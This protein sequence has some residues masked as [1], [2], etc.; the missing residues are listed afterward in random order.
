MLL[1]RESD[2]FHLCVGHLPSKN[3]YLFAVGDDESGY[4]KLLVASKLT[5][6]LSVSLG[7]YSVSSACGSHPS[8]CRKLSME[9]IETGS[10][11]SRHIVLVPLENG[12]QILE[13]IY[14]GTSNNQLSLVTHH[15]LLFSGVNGNHSCGPSLGVHKIGSDYFIPCIGTDN[16]YYVCELMLNLTTIAQSV[17]QPCR[18][19]DISNFASGVNLSSISNIAVINES[20]VFLIENVLYELYPRTSSNRPFTHIFPTYCSS[21]SQLLISPQDENKLLIYHRNHNIITY[22]HNHHQ[23]TRIEE[24]SN[25]PYPCSPTAEYIVHLSQNQL[26]F[27]YKLNN[28]SDTVSRIFESP[29]SSINFHSGACFESRGNHLFVYIDTNV[30]TYIFNATSENLRLLPNTQGCLEPECE[31]P[32]VFYN[33]YIVIRNKL[34]RHVTVFDALLN[35]SVINL[36]GTPLQ[37][38]TLISDL[39]AITIQNVP[40][41]TTTNSIESTDSSNAPNQSHDDIKRGVPLEV[42]VPAVILSI[43]IVITLIAIT[44]ILV[45][46]IKKW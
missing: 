19:A 4:G 22:D 1:S 2:V 38:V 7:G 29:S 42:V 10:F 15:T 14:N 27:S 28:D 17:L 41:S 6:T 31:V 34:R 24:A 37:L 23:I 36:G 13:L 20:L 21:V 30:G 35:Q 5:N 9:T 32:L 39:P 33:R 44:V 3:D 11:T 8:R 45:I 40:S 26:E 18:P 25:V 12:V 46:I 43:L 16:L